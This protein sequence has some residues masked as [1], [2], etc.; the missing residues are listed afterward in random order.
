MRRWFIT[1]DVTTKASAIQISFVSYPNRHI[2]F[3][4]MLIPL[5]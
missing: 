4:E 3:S 2:D 5:L 1:K